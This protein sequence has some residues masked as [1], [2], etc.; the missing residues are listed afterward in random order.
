M[1]GTL[2]TIALVAMTA[3]SAASAGTSIYSASKSSK[4]PNLEIPQLQSAV[5]TPDVTKAATTAQAAVT[6][7]KRAIA[8]QRS[9]YT[10]PLGIGA[11]AGIARK[12]LLGQ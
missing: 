12:T 6:Q 7:K 1:L 11:D 3:A 2:A 5:S 10:S 8:G 9:I 4:K